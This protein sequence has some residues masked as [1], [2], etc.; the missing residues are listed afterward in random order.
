MR[1]ARDEKRVAGAG[2]RVA[3]RVISLLSEAPLARLADGLRSGG[4]ELTRY[5]HELCDRIEQVEP[6]VQALLPEPGRR[7]RLLATAAELLARYPD[8]DLR[9]P[10]FGVPVGVKDIF[11]VSGFPTQAGSALPASELT[12]VEGEAVRSLRA[13]GALVLGKTVTTEFAYFEPGPTRN[14]HHPGHTPG[15]SSSGSAA[16]VAAGLAPL[17]LGTQTVGS[18]IRPAAFCGVVGFKPTYDRLPTSGLLYFAPSVDHVGLFTQD[19]A[20]MVLAASVLCR[21]WRPARPGNRLVLGIPEGPY[22]AQVSEEGRAA[23]AAQ[24]ERLAAAGYDLIRVPLLSDIAQINERHR[25]L[26][27]HEFAQQHARLFT[28]YEPLYRSRTAALLREGQTVPA[29]E[30]A[31]IRDARTGLRL[32]VEQTMQTHGI[33]VWLCPAALGPAPASLDSTGDPVM[34]LPWTYLGLPALT[35][36]AG[37][38]DNGLPLGLQIVAAWMADEKLLA[39]ASG[40]ETALAS[41]VARRR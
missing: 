40:I 25:R 34:N 32:E 9:P 11:H 1:E 24:M 30:A 38:A 6:Y 17:A 16:A 8:A 18:V 15:G 2:V 21:A 39:W 4:I 26:I 23:Y 12:G 20:G 13:A 33:D 41:G 35:V 27:A 29:V 10:L 36:P 22:L 14:P 5:V 31:V 19:V 3:N 37:Q 28:L 7:Q